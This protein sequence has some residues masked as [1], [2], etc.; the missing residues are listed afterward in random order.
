[1]T[2]PRLSR[3]A[4][5]RIAEQKRAE[6]QERTLTVIERGVATIER[7]ARTALLTQIAY[8][9][10]KISQARYEATCARLNRE[11][12]A[13]RDVRAAGAVSAPYDPPA[14]KS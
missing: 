8:R 13:M 5:A 9:K 2:R 3:A 11:L 4:R 14:M 10:G 6:E 12:D 1:M 7:L